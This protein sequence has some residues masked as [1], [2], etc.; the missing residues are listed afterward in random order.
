MVSRVGDLQDRLISDV[1]C[2]GLDLDF[3]L[4]LRPYSKNYFGVYN[5]NNDKIVLYVYQDRNKKHLYPY[6]TI[7][8]S[9]IHEIVHYIQW[10]DPNF[11]RNKGVMHDTQFYGLYNSYIDKMKSVLLLREVVHSEKAR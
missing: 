2:L 7:L 11:V 5:P 10:N 4:E 8:S 3:D 1:A 9:F 6:W